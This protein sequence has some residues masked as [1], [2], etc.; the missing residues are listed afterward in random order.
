MKS[1]L[2]NQFKKKSIQIRLL[3]TNTVFLFL[4]SSDAVTY[5]IFEMTDSINE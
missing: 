3:V 5:E 4:K 1:K 2:H